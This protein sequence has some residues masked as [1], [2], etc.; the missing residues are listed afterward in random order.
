M[1]ERDK[2][3][4]NVRMETSQSPKTVSETYSRLFICVPDKTGIC[5]FV[6]QTTRLESNKFIHSQ[7]IDDAQVSY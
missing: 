7:M 6:V 5:N 1:F 4:L 2:T 3:K